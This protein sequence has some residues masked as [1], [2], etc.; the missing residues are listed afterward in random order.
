MVVQG[1]GAGVLGPLQDGFVW[2]PL[3][4]LHQLGLCVAALA[5]LG[6]IKDQPGFLHS[7]L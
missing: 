7:S 2:P 4:L 3:L 6:H 5:V 1:E